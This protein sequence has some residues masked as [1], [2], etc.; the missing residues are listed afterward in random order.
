MTARPLSVP[1]PGDAAH[2]RTLYRWFETAALSLPDHPALEIGDRVVT[3]AQLRAMALTLAERLV[4][5]HGGVPRRV[6]LVASRTVAAYAGYLA[7]QRL[8]A[9]VV[10]L[11]PDHPEPR[12]LDV[13]QRAGVEAALVDVRSDG[14]FRLLPERYRPTVLELSDDDL[15][16]T[17]PLGTGLPPVPDDLDAE[18]Y[19]IFTSGSTGQPKGV[20]IRHRHVS[21]YLAYN[22]ARYELAPGCRHPQVYGLTFDVHCYDLFVTWGG[23]ATLV[24]PSVEELFRP[25]D[26][27]VDK[28]LTHWSSVPSVL[29][30][31]QRLG[32]VPLGRAVT[33]RHTSFG[34]ETVTREN[35]DLWREVAPHAQIHNAYGPTEVSI[36]CVNH[37][38]TGPSSDWPAYEGGAVPIGTPYPHMEA[39]LLGED[40]LP[41]ADGELCLRGPQ[42]FDGY[43]DP[44][45]NTGR[46]L[47]YEE[48]GGPAVVYDGSGPL[49]ARHWYRTGDRVR[50]EGEVLVHRG[51]LDQQ[52]KVRGHRVEIGEVEAVFR[53]H[54]QVVDVA[55]VPVPAEGGETELAAAYAGREVEPE[56]FDA[57]LRDRVPLHMVPSRIRLMDG[58]PLN[59]NGK[60]DRT[61]L[62]RILGTRETS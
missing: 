53:R 47:T 10:P 22:I 12:N 14:L 27:I 62:A 13:A 7:V 31:A 50:R 46:F 40:G 19:L 36:G 43:L 20:P 61:A 16:G 30:E 54:P 18:A 35:V 37:R 8:G 5:K 26:F 42:R 28:G 25:V 2:Q 56:A 1:D 11:N 57:W 33:L 9:S 52:V 55:V 39:V 32:H 45:E 60:T 41:A 21:P 6:A 44:G 29:R 59:D 34:A 23:G 49:T 58:L 3:Y 4:H 38:L 48:G 17:E 24:V 15:S 51:R